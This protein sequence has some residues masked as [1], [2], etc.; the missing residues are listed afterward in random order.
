MEE[1]DDDADGN[2]LLVVTKEM[3]EDGAVVVAT[4]VNKSVN[5]D[6]VDEIGGRGD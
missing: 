3:T 2:A 4:K 5:N 6:N 1:G